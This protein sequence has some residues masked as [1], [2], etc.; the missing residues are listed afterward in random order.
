MIKTAL[1][2]TIDFLTMCVVYGVFFALAVVLI[3]KIWGDK[4]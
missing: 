4:K 3:K 2:A 1:D